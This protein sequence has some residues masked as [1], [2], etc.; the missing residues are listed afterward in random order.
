MDG[1]PNQQ[2]NLN[3]PHLPSE[4]FP[5]YEG[6]EKRNSEKRE[7]LPTPEVGTEHAH[8]NDAPPI[9]PSIPSD[10]AQLLAQSLSANDSTDSPS[11]SSIPTNMDD[12]DALIPKEWVERAKRLVDQTRGN[13]Y[14][15]SREFNKLKAEYIK[16][17]YNMTI[18][19][20]DD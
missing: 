1:F 12:T 17:R 9:I 13:P 18:K 5:D 14:E 7:K 15:Q 8:E 20:A 19:V 10:Q 6:L 16:Q 3:L 4:S 2:P 11:A